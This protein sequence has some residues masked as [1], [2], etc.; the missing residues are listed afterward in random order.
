MGS[1]N[2][3]IDQRR[4]KMGALPLDNYPGRFP[5]GA[6]L[7]IGTLRD[8]GGVNI[9]N[10]HDPALEGDVMTLEAV[11]IP[12]SI[13]P[14]MVRSGKG[15]GVFQQAGFTGTYHQSLFNI[16]KDLYPQKGMLFH[17]GILIFRQLTGFKQ[18]PVV[19]RNLPQIVK[20]G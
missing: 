5:M 13:P 16:F 19:Y 9:G 10:G 1:R 12:G 3:N 17:F 14:F 7:F 18:D 20:L 4:I 8:K 11:G 2:K 6:G 15:L